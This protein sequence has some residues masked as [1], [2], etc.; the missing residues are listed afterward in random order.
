MYLLDQ[1]NEAPF[2]SIKMKHTGQSWP[3]AFNTGEV[4]NPVC[5]HGIQIVELK[6]WSTISRVLLKR[7]KHLIQIEIPFFIIF[8]RNLVVYDVISLANLHILK[9]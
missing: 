7:I 8:D 2:S 6:L 5:Y 4:W 9:T 3:E 1:A